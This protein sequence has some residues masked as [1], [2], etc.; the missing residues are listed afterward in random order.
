MRTVSNLVN[1][2]DSLRAHPL[3][4]VLTMLGVVVGVA[5]VVA[6]MAVGEGARSRI[7]AQIQSL[8]GNL[9]LAT[10]GS[11][12]T[13]GVHQGSGSGENLTIADA[14]AIAVEVPGVVVT[15]PSVFKRV[16]VVRGN[17]NWSTT[18]QGITNE[19][20]AAR[21]WR[22]ASGRPFSSTE[23]AGG[24]KVALLGR[25]VAERL[26][27]GEEPSGQLIRVGG[28]PYAVI[29]VLEG[30]GQSSSG[31]DQ[32]DK[33]MVPLATAQSRI[34]GSLR[35]RLG[36]VQYVMVK[37]AEQERLA[38]AAEEIRLLLRQRHALAAD[39]DDDFS[40]RNLAD[41]QASREAATGVLT[42]WLS[43]VA[44][45]SLIVGGISIMNIMLVSVTERTR[46]IGLRLAVGA[47]PADVRNQFLAEA[48]VLSLI[49][50][51]CGLAV[52]AAIAWVIAVVQDLPIIIRPV[53]LV[54]S[55]GFALVTGIFFGLYP[56][57]KA[58]RLAPAEALRAE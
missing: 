20:L 56:A 52:G 10:P 53:S 15:A 57:L 51:I 18:V 9:L 32:D 16:Q 40:L 1:A 41:V 4:S 30:K 21:E 47:R 38:T 3:R 19:Y 22:L 23:E 34:S 25:T 8:G 6:V 5:A 11:A 48:V 37:I 14:R 33:V 39:E 28:A 24:A 55:A 2:L 42:F 27:P 49:G 54:V 13:Q 45:V 44:S 17:A 58:S 7:I 31:A 35:A 26:F 46:E 12:R 50:A 43:A 36:A 29:G